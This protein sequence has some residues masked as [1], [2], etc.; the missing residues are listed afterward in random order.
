MDDELLEC[1]SVVPLLQQ[2]DLQDYHQSDAYEIP[3]HAVITDKL[4][5]GLIPTDS[6]RCLVPHLM[7]MGLSSLLRFTDSTYLDLIRSR[8]DFGRDRRGLYRPFQSNLWWIAGHKRELAPDC[9]L[10]LSELAQ[11]GNL[12]FV[13]EQDPDW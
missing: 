10:Q 5:H 2:L 4:L 1:L 13:F 6:D 11:Q 3:D 12:I 8:V 7:Y 9:A